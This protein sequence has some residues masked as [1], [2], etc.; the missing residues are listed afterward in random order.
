MSIFFLVVR[1]L[2]IVSEFLSKMCTSKTLLY[3]LHP[4]AGEF[5]YW[6]DMHCSKFIFRADAPVE[7]VTN[8]ILRLTKHVN[9]N[10]LSKVT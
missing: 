10:A 6:N 3:I 9:N 8:G 2:V 4:F 5:I 7:F 1:V